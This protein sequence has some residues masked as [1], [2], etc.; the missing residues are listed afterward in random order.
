MKLLVKFNL[1]FLF[2]FGLGLLATG[3]VARTSLQA[4][5]REQVLQEA[6]LM[7][8]MTRSTRDYTAQ[9]VRPLL[10]VRQRHEKAFFAQTVPAYSATQVFAYLHSRYPAYTYKEATLNPTNLADRAVDWEADVVS[11]F[12]NDMTRKELVGQR[13]AATG[14]ALFLAKPIRADAACLECHSV[15]HAAPAAMVKAYG[16]DHGFGWKPNEVVAAQIVSVPMALPIEIADRAFRNLILWL[17]GI[18]LATLILLDLGLYFAVVRPVTRM[19]A[20]A[21]AISRGDVDVPELPVRGGD[22]IATLAASFNRMHRSLQKAMSL[23]G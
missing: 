23:L 16:P 1:V 8:E 20:A 11:T 17:A 21:D 3:Y 18:S 19:S 5:A 14:D 4:G 2:V 7:M 13:R 6:R 15:P 10:D 9:Q 12:R 22:E